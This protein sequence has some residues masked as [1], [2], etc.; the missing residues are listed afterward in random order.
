VLLTMWTW[1]SQKKRRGPEGLRL[2]FVSY[3]YYIKL[4]GVDRHKLEL[5][6]RNGMTELG[7]KGEI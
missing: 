5:Y 1:R 3:I 4:G 6:I 2:N 7:G